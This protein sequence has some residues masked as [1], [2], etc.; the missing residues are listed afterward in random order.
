[1]IE[2]DVQLGLLPQTKQGKDITINFWSMDIDNANIF[3]TDENGMQMVN[4]TLNKRSSYSLKASNSVSQ[5]ISAN[6]YPVTRAI[7]IRDK[8]SMAQMTVMTTKVHGGSVLKPGRIE[9]MH[10]R[11]LIYDDDYSKGVTLD[12]VEPV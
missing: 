1:M 9:L 11:R 7:A 5:N 2:W 10:S 6:Y 12:D 8:V 4:R 3:W